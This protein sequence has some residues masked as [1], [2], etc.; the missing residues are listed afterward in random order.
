MKINEVI[1]KV[2]GQYRLYSKKGKNLGTYPSRAGAEKREKQ[3]QYFKH[4]NEAEVGHDE[5]LTNPMHTVVVDTPSDLDWYKLGQHFPT[6]ANQDAEEFGAGGSDTVITFASQEEADKFRSLMKQ[7]GVA[8][9]DIGG[10]THHQ[11]IHTTSQVDEVYSTT[12]VKKDDVIPQDFDDF[13]GKARPVAKIN[14]YI[15]DKYVDKYK[16]ITYLVQNPKGKNYLGELHLGYDDEDKFYHSEVFL[17]PELQGTGLAIELYKYAITEDNIT[18]VSDVTQTPGSEKLWQKLAN[19]PSVFVYKWDKESNKFSHWDDEVS[20]AHVNAK[21][22]I[23]K[24]KEVEQEM[25]DVYDEISTN[26]SNRQELV[27]KYEY[28]TQE[29]AEL[30]DEISGAGMLRLVATKS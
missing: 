20:D 14:N 17:V 16:N 22:T 24:I 10:T 1:R 7:K 25:D 28:L 19:D 3:V 8:T 2:G 26:P 30:K 6:L 12:N 9:R 29:Y 18:I 5:I 27:Q 4:A 23:A 13:I 21:E 15:I 11:E